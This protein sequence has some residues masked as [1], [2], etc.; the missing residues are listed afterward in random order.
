M[1]NYTPKSEEQLARE[2]LMP[3][4]IYD[5]EVVETRDKPSKAGNPMFTLKLHV[6]DS[7][8]STNVIYDYIVLGNN[9]GE[10]K[11]RH[12]ADACGIIDIY[13]TGKM[14]ESDFQGKCGKVEIKTQN[15]NDDFP[16][17]K[18]VVRDYVKREPGQVDKPKAVDAIADDEVPF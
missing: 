12:A 5:F 18:N 8:G 1:N 15:G 14:N 4:G 11:L 10:R 7:A 9:F 17:P 16:L 3:D 6:F 13:E 2:G